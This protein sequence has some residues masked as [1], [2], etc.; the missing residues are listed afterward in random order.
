[1]QLDHSSV[2]NKM[3][4]HNWIVSVADFILAQQIQKFIILL[5]MT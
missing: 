1:M 5:I 4:T 2:Q 3:I